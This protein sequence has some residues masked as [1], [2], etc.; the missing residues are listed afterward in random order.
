MNIIIPAGTHIWATVEYPTSHRTHTIN[1]VIESHTI[2][3][4][5]IRYRVRD[6]ETGGVYITNASQVRRMS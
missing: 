5:A 6:H 2:A 1:A 3:R 4:G